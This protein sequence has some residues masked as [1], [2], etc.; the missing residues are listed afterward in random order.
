MSPTIIDV[1]VKERERLRL[2]LASATRII[3]A[4][5]ETTGK[6]G[7]V[8]IPNTTMVLAENPRNALEMFYDKTTLV[9]NIKAVKPP[10]I[11][12]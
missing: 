8:S 12:N 4:M 1:L 3:W 2:E 10:I 9:T 11:V 5:A 6:D 7:L